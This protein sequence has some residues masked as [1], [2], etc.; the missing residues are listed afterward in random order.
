[1]RVAENHHVRRL[2]NDAAL[3]GL[4]RFAR[5]NNVV[6]E[7]FV[8]TGLDHLRLLEIK[9]R[10]VVAQHSGHWR[11]LFQLEN[12]PPQPDIAAVKDVVHAR[13]ELGNFRV[14]MPV[15]VGEDADFH[16]L[17]V[18]SCGL[19]SVEPLNR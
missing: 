1:M 12:Q 13:E 18:V 10:V 7:E 2:A 8:A 15:R 17:S 16:Y 6:H 9:S 11:D 19:E 3:K 5:V 14:E 4:R